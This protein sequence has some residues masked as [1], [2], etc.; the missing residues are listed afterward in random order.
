M[1]YI[2]ENPPSHPNTTSHRLSELRQRQHSV[3]SDISLYI[4][5]TTALVNPYRSEESNNMSEIVF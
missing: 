2:S 1:N 3:I 5:T 4:E